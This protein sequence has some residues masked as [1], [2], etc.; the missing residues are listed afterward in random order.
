MFLSLY[1]LVKKV[2]IFAFSRMRTFYWRN[3]STESCEECLENAS[4]SVTNEWLP[5]ADLV[6]QWGD[7]CPSDFLDF[8]SIDYQNKSFA[9]T[10]FLLLDQTKKKTFELKTSEF[11]VH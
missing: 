3:L 8:N 6:S 11:Y 1:C 9:P 7:K 4:A 2:A 5:A 10:V